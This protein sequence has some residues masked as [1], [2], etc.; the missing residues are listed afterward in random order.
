MFQQKVWKL[1][2]NPHSATSFL[3]IC[4]LHVLLPSLHW[5][6]RFHVSLEFLLT[7]VTGYIFFPKIFHPPLFLKKPT[8]QPNKKSPTC[9][10]LGPECFL[11]QSAPWLITHCVI[12]PFAIFKIILNFPSFN[13]IE[14]TFIF[15]LYEIGAYISDLDH[16][17]FDL[18]CFQWSF[19]PNF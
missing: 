6:M 19:E 2:N 8:P 11:Q 17:L 5:N 3:H 1:E 12:K 4:F 10:N 16:S 9:W 18:V 7:V 15:V 13:L 14:C